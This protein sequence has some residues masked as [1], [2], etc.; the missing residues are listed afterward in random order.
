MFSY[1]I[2][3]SLI[4][5]TALSGCI[6]SSSFFEKVETPLTWSTYQTQIIE[7]EEVQSLK[8]WW[9]K[10]D[11]ETL[12]NLI[13]TAMD[14]SPTRKIAESRVREARG[15]RRSAKGRLFPTIGLSGLIGQQEDGI[16]DTD[17][18]YEAGFDAS[19]ELDIF[20]KNT[21]TLNAADENIA[22]LTEQYRNTTISL[23]AEISRDYID[24]RTFEEQQNIAQKN[25]TIQ[26]KTLELV[27]NQK[28]FG[29]APQLDVERAENLVNTTRS[30]IPEFKR[31]ADN[32][33]LRLSVLIGILPEDLKPLLENETNIPNGN[34]EPV[35]LAPADIIAL[36]PD[37]RAAL[38][39]LNAATSLAQA[40]ATDIFPKFT[41]SGFFGVV[42]RT[43]VST[44]NIWNVAIGAA[45]NLIDF[46]RIQGEID[47]AKAV[48][49]R[50]FET[51]R[52]TILEAVV[53]VETALNDYSRINQQNIYLQD[54]FK[55]AEKALELSQILYKEGE[56]D[57]I[58]VLES[59]RTLNEANAS[60]IS[61]K[62]S[63]SQSLVRLYKSLGIY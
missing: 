26:E 62:S 21:K 39:N 46:G 17:S 11:D 13:I 40:E 35:L 19:Y 60:L 41:I 2:F 56:T 29:E 8:N 57:F 63:K 34:I 3:P 18:F 6:S 61:A 36:R 50:A 54:A 22:S 12:N 15:I 52:R 44:A 58:N 16:S 10:F 31:L 25:L 47:A 59:Q 51:Y 38:S 5:I 45:V 49:V 28:E 55:N 53:E 27:R 30:S 9:Q 20:G 23:I 4:C 14:N 33:R 7:Q 32:S 42:D 48:E 24:F 37:I 43:F 1:K